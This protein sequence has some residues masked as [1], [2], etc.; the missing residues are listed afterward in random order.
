VAAASPPAWLSPAGPADVEE[1]I[2]SYYHQL[3][4]DPNGMNV[5]EFDVRSRAEPKIRDD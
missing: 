1:R 5:M 2:R 4:R 3:V